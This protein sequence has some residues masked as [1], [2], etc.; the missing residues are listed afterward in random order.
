MTSWNSSLRA[1]TLVVA[2]LLAARMPAYVTVDV[3]DRAK[4]ARLLEQLAGL[5][6]VFAEIRHRG[7]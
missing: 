4:A 3:E 2:A 5:V 1:V 6:V 7:Q